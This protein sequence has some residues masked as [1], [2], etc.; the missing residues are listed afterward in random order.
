MFMPDFLGYGRLHARGARKLRWFS[1]P[2]LGNKRRPSPMKR[3][4][5]GVYRGTRG[6]GAHL[7]GEKWLSTWKRGPGNAYL[8]GNTA[9]TGKRRK[10]RRKRMRPGSLCGSICDATRRATPVTRA[11]QVSAFALFIVRNEKL[12]KRTKNIV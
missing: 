11:D 2:R 8:T 3:R 9:R 1:S 7:S 12:G 5:D 10:C 6:R 4:R